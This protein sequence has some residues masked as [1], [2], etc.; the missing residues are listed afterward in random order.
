MLNLAA[1]NKNVE[2]E[3][4]REGDTG[5]HTDRQ[6]E[7]KR[8]ENKKRDRKREREREGG[9]GRIRPTLI[10]SACSKSSDVYFLVLHTQGTAKN[11]IL[12]NLLNV[13]KATAPHRSDNYQIR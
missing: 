10:Y 9:G 4:E 1:S 12:T 6:K 11:I 2:R 8:D 5:R 13:V 7:R 3:K